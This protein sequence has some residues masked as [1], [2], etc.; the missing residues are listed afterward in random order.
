MGTYPQVTRQ[1]GAEFAP[2]GTPPLGPTVAYKGSWDAS[3]G[4]LPSPK[5]VGDMY[6]ISA[7]GTVSG[8]VYEVDDLVM[9]TGSFWYIIRKVFSDGVAPLNI[10]PLAARPVSPA[11]NDFWILVPTSGPDAGKKFVEWFDGTVVAS[12]EMTD[13]P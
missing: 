2:D 4:T 3:G 7:E 13:V 1:Q 11:A 12:V 5:D 9:W 10:E 8:V 6:T